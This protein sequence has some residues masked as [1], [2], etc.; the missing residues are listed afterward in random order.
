MGGGGSGER[1]GVAALSMERI[2]TEVRGGRGGE[3]GEPGTDRERRRAGA[4]SV[5]HM[6]R[7][8][9]TAQ[10]S[11]TRQNGDVSSEVNTQ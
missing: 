4:S 5:C 11:Q 3:T 2:P 6:V 1:G 7:R 10:P 8:Q 9:F